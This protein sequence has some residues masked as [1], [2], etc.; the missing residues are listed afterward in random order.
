MKNIL[1]LS[2]DSAIGGKVK[3]LDLTTLQMQG[4]KFFHHEVSPIYPSN[5]TPEFLNRN[6]SEDK[7]LKIFSKLIFVYNAAKSKSKSK[8]LAIILSAS[9]L[10]PYK[11]RNLH[12]FKSI[13]QQLK[14][15][16]NTVS[17]IV[18]ICGLLKIPINPIFFAQKKILRKFDFF[19]DYLSL[20]KIDTVVVFSSGYDNL[21]HLINYHDKIN[22]KFI[23]VIN[24]WD[25][26][27]SKCFVTENFDELLL[28]NH[29]QIQ[30]VCKL[31][32]IS[33]EKLTVIGSQTATVLTLNMGL[34]LQEILTFQRR[35]KKVCSTL[36]S[37]IITMKLVM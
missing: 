24:N 19:F 21:V 3:N 34:I 5:V 18:Y 26:P 13:V 17:I 20:S 31:N 16:I 7:I 10:G 27:S 25:N 35:I 22:C 6:I 32:T 33:K 23:L 15:P 12:S 2:G 4:F 1:F 36:D 11:L 14:K 9:I 28:W 8:S 37:K 30:H 29:Q